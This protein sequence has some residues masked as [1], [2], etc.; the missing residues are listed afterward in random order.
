M[1]K[2]IQNKQKAV[3]IIKKIQKKNQQQISRINKILVQVQALIK[4]QTINQIQCNKL[5]ATKI[6]EYG[7]LQ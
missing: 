2:M 6:I 4:N 5:R 7:M 3:Q 1:K